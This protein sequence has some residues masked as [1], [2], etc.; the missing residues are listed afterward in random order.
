[1]KIFFTLNF[2][3]LLIVN[4]FGQPAFPSPGDTNS[5]GSGTNSYSPAYTE[6]V[7]SYPTNATLLW[8]LAMPS[9]PGY[10]SLSLSPIGT[11]GTLY[12][13]VTSACAGDCGNPDDALWSINISAINTTNVNYPSPVDFTN[14]VDSYN[15]YG[16]QLTPV[17]GA[18]GTIYGS[19]YAGIFSAF[20]PTNGATLWDFETQIGSL[21]FQ[22]QPCIGNDG[23]VYITC[24]NYIYALTNAFGL[25]NFYFANTNLYPYALTNVGIKWIYYT[26]AEDF[27]KSS[28]AIG[29]DGTV[30][31]NSDQNQLFALNSTN[32]ALKWVT[33]AISLPVIGRGASTPA[34]GFDGSIYFGAGH[35]FCAIN[36]NATVTN[37]IIGFKWVYT[38]AETNNYDTFNWSPVI[39]SDGTVYVEIDGDWIDGL[40]NQLF[41]INQTNGI[42]K[43]IINLG[44]EGGYSYGAGVGSNYKKGSIAIAADGEI[45]LADLDGTLYSFSP[46]GTTNWTYNTGSLALNSP[47]IAPDGTLYVETVFA[48]SYPAYVYAFAG[49]APISCSS[50]PE[51]GRNARRTA[52]MSSAHISSPYMT[53]NGFQFTISGKTN[54]PVCSCATSDFIYWTNMSQTV[55]TNGTANYLDTQSSNYP[56]RFYRAVP[57]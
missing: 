26:N 45:Y 10:G 40:S 5:Y 53:T 55:L 37:G 2:F 6:P 23:T 16:D 28:P 29:S 42:P 14:W 35:Y 51:G 32:G 49:P 18:D 12:I 17:I 9:S 1:M 39:G 19:L 30:Y 25:T 15:D 57:Q 54:V 47:L 36:P 56:Y 20:N 22:G 8:Y 34:I 24:D 48:D 31:V 33:A 21:F 41:A 3:A 52:A 7:F 11:N 46:S 13:P 43:W 27:R 44:F 38:D 4:V 50:W